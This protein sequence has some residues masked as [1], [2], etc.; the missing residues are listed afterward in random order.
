M[1][2]PLAGSLAK[3]IGKAM[4]GLFLDAVLTRAVHAAP[5]PLEP[6]TPG[7][8]TDTDYPCKAIHEEWSAYHRQGGLVLSSDRRVLVLASTV[9]VEPAPGDRITIRGET[10]TI[11]EQ[12][13]GQPAVST[14]PAKA[15]WVLRCRT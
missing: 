10:F 5:D 7:T 6:W 15:T 1:T 13:S 14:D 9:A 8:S 11:V 4:S 12:G 3:T 2:S